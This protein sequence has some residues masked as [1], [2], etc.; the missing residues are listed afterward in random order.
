L[1]GGILITPSINLDID[2]VYG[3]SGGTNHVGKLL[4]GGWQSYCSLSGG[5]LLAGSIQLSGNPSSFYQFGGTNEV[6]D[7]LLIAAGSSY[8][9]LEGELNVPAIQLSGGFHHASGALNMAGA[10]TLTNG[11]WD[12]QTSGQQFGALQL[13]GAISVLSL[14]MSG[15]ALRFADS[16]S[17]SWSNGAA[18]GVQ[19]WSGSLYGGGEQQ[20][21]FGNNSAALTAPQLSQI[22]FQNPTGLAAGTYPARMLATG[23]IVPDT[24]AV[25]PMKMSAPC[26]ASDGWMQLSLGAEIGKS[27]DIEVSTDLV[28]W[29]RWTNEF[30]SNG[31]ICIFDSATNCPQKFYRAQAAP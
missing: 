4:A 25:L 7:N 16:S 29:T 2:C 19:N 23:E 11:T 28:N 5:W 8:S 14:P 9:L 10:L 20:I 6:S 15:C 17:L 24:G 13:A 26:A 22:Q 30:N 18:L 31:T 21:I 12:E 27:Y 1:A 3:Q